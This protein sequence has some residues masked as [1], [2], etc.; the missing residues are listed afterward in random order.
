M[1]INFYKKSIS[2]YLLLPIFL[3]AFLLFLLFP[4]NNAFAIF[5]GARDSVYYDSESKK[6]NVGKLNFNPFSGNKDITW[7]LT[8]PV[9]ASYMALAG[10]GV[11]IANAAADK[12][13]KPTNSIGAPTILAEQDPFPFPPAPYPEPTWP[14]RLARIGSL[15]AKRMGEQ[16]VISA[17]LAAG[18]ASA[19]VD[20]VLV[21]TDV[22]KCCIG[23]NAALVTAYSLAVT[24]LAVIYGFA[25]EA[26]KNTQICGYQWNSWADIRDSEGKM[27]KVRGKYEGS[28]QL[29]LDNVFNK[30]DSSCLE[31]FQPD[32]SLAAS[33]AGF[34]ANTVFDPASPDVK[35]R[36]ISN[37][38][39]R[40]FLYGGIEFED[41]GP[42]ACKNPSSWDSEKRRRILGY[43]NDLQRYYL[44]GPG[45][46]PVYGCSRFLQQKGQ[47]AEQEAFNCCNKRSQETICI[48]RG[49][50]HQ[51][52]KLGGRC[53]LTGIW[54]EPY[55]SKRQQ[56]YICAKSYSVCP[57]NHPVGGGTEEEV[58]DSSNPNS[59]ANTCQ[60]MNHCSVRPPKA[61]FNTSDLKAGFISAS[62]KNLKGDSQ[63]NYLFDQSALKSKGSLNF[64][65][66]LIQCFK[67]TM[68]NLFLNV[69]GDTVCADA[70][71]MVDEDGKCPSGNYL[72]QK[73]KSLGGE[74]FFVKVQNWLKS[75][76]KVALTLS[77]ALFGAM[78]LMGVSPIQKK[79][80]I[81]YIIKIALI[82]YFALGTAWQTF[83]FQKVL[84][85]SVLMA[86]MTLFI[87]NEAP[88]L[89][90]T[91]LANK[92]AKNN[93]TVEQQT[94]AEDAA[95]AKALDENLDGC[96]FPKYDANEVD[97]KDQAAYPA[98]K[99]YL[100]IWDTLDCKIAR[101][102]G[103]GPEVSVP[104]LVLMVVGGFFTGSLGLIFVVGA[105]LF[106]FFLLSMTIKAMHS[107][108]MSIVY[109][110]LLIY[111]SP[112]TITLSLFSRTKSIFS[113]WQKNLLGVVVQ[114]LI[115]FSYLGLMVAIFDN[116]V[117]GKDVKF[118]GD[119]VKGPKEVICND[120]ASNS[121]LYC[122]FRI[123][124]L[125][126]FNGLE[127][128]GITIP[129]LKNLTSEKVGSI[130]KAAMIAF[131]FSSFMDQI[132]NLA[133]TLAGGPSL[134][135]T[136]G[137][138]ATEMAKKAF[139]GLD[140]VR[141]RGMRAARKGV[142][143]ALSS[144]SRVAGAMSV[145]SV[146]DAGA[147]KAVP[148]DRIGGTQTNTQSGPQDR[149]T[150]PKKTAPET[151]SKATQTDPQKQNASPQNASSQSGKGSQGEG[152]KVGA[153]DRVVGN[154]EKGPEKQD[155]VADEKKAVEQD[156]AGEQ[157]AA[158]T[159]DR[160]GNN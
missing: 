97:G 139:T 11:V 79:D 116:V 127:V 28:Y 40:E 26:Y 90:G 65:A 20:S 42:D 140:G 8:N 27:T 155:R 111:V 50:K 75:S 110:V 143:S 76:I 107:F 119:P 95:A 87:D 104:N 46:S 114:P 5:T 121:S 128:I 77:V 39:Y 3:S 63:N 6:C 117:I 154:D 120:K 109:I 29:C 86:D 124:E 74:S 2:G 159:Q 151:A 113:S 157:E 48:T 13:C 153:Q 53:N 59:R 38:F 160:S 14:Y 152:S 94:Q 98:G 106:A 60:F 82:M 102:I 105:F 144:V 70:N 126:S 149:V 56:N 89:T 129:I 123:S 81:P 136:W 85:S 125:D 22:N 41:A 35:K 66:P 17:R 32:S 23:G 118:S 16:S 142:S 84:D 132:F 7:E 69:A 158:N 137:I 57:Y 108:I 147:A 96:Q 131:L 115:L 112:I 25:N 148:Q 64:S 47:I 72:F 15:C 71:E 99:E 18:D 1:R 31:A 103:Y 150:D 12:L 58:F 45:K 55:E 19:Q 36:E 37:R 156:R 30:A 146:K 130:F 134:K 93:V 9:C 73:G 141:L 61:R 34:L 54:Y 100:K 88:K 92:A 78:V 4:Q 10:A 49:D 21:G 24:E 145:K 43:D 91:E 67:E 133:K 138:S 135:P 62:C 80:L 33:F 51:F 52:C 122:I 101:A 44:T 83:F 68:E